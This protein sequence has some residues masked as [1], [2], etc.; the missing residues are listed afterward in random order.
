MLV[1][2]DITCR[3]HRRRPPLPL[4]TDITI[5][6]NRQIRVKIVRRGE[7]ETLE[8]FI[9]SVIAKVF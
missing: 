9:G 4:A 1:I 3:H 8:C 7:Y 5:S 6:V 2:V